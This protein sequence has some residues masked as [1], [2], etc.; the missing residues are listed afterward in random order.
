MTVNYGGTPDLPT[1]V[2]AV[3]E[4][5][6]MQTIPV[7]WDFGTPVFDQNTPAA[8]DFS[9]TLAMP[10]GVTNTNNLKAG[11][12]VIVEPQ[13]EPPQEQQQEQPTGFFD[14]LAGLVSQVYRLL[15][16]AVSR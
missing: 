12:R 15:T 11:I 13:E 7:T 4:D 16:G 1:A 10:E 2:T 14:R 6:S 9:G 3:M 8:Y 5:N